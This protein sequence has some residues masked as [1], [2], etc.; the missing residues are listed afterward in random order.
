MPLR[1][2]WPPPMVSLPHWRLCQ[3]VLCS[4][5][6]LSLHAVRADLV[7]EANT[8]LN[9][10]ANLPTATGFETINALGS[11]TFSAPMCTAFP[12]GETNRL[13][14]LQR[15][16]TIRVV[17]NLGT[18]PASAV[19]MNLTTYLSN[20]GTPLNQG[21]ENGMLTMVFHPDYNQNGYFYVYYSIT[22][23]GQLYQRLAR[24]KATGTAGNYNAATSAD[25]ATQ[26]PLLTMLDQASNH[27][28]GDLAF[29]ADG[30]LYLSLGDEG[31]GGDQY[32]NARFINKDFW[33]QML[34]LDVDNDP[35]NFVPNAHSQASAAFPSAVHAGT[36][37]VPADNPF[38]GYTSWHGVTIS[39][40]TVRTEIFA[41]GLRNPFRFT[42]DPGTGRIFLGDV[43]QNIYEEVD[44]IVKGGDYGWS[45]REG[46]HA[47]GSPPSPTSPPA[48]YSTFRKD[49]IF[50][51]DHTDNGSGNDSIIHGATVCGGMIY[52]GN[53]F[54]ELYGKYLFADFGEGILA[55]LTETSAGTWTGQRLAINV[56]DVVDFGIDPRNGEPLL[57]T[58]SGGTIS[59]L[60]RT[61]T[62]PTQPPATLSATGAFSDLATLTPNTGIVP[63]E[64]NVD[65]WSDYA[66]KSRWFSI[67]NTSDTMTWSAS[68]NWTFPTGM[69]WIKHFDFETTRG[70]PATRRKLETRFLV[71]TATGVYGLS[72]KWRADQTD[73]DLVAEQGLSEVV[74]SSSPAQTWRY[75]SRG[76][77]IACHSGVAGHALSFNSPQINRAHDYG[78]ASQNQIEALSSAGYFSSPA[79]G[80]GSLPA[81][82]RADDG[83]QSLEW[84]VRSYLAVN[85]VQCHQ[86][87]GAAQGNWD[88]RYTTPI[89]SANLIYGL[90]LNDGGDSDN[91]FVTPEDP[92]HSMLLKRQQGLSA[93]RMPPLATNERDLVAEQLITDWINSLTPIASGVLA[94]DLPENSTITVQEDAG[95]VQIP[96]IRTDGSEGSVGFSI[97]TVNGTATTGTDFTAQAS[98]QTMGNGVE[99][100]DVPI[101]ILNPANTSEA[102]ETFTVMISAPTGGATLG[103]V[104]SVTVRIIDSS[105]TTAP[106]APSITTPAAAALVGANTGATINVTGTATDNKGVSSVKVKLNNGTFVDAALTAPE[107]ASTNWSLAVTPVTGA[108]T[109]TVQSF[110]THNNPS[111]LATRTFVVTRPLVVNASSTLGTVTAGFSPSSFR[112]VNKSLTITATPKPP[113]TTPAFAGAIFTGWN[114]GGQD[115][116]NGNVAFTPQRLNMATSALEKQSIIFL[117]REGLILTANFIANPFTSLAGTYNGLIRP[118]PTQPPPSGST[119]NNSTEG[120]FTA[121][122][123][124]TGAFSGKLTIDGLVLNVAGAFDNNGDA[125]FGTARTLT[126]T[127]ARPSKP[128]LIVALHLNSAENQVD[129]TVDDKISGTV[130]AREFKQSVTTSVSEVDSDRAF[131]NGTTLLVPAAYLGAANAN[132]VF[133]TVLPA[134]DVAD[135]PP[136]F[137]EKDYPRGSG[138]ATITITKGGVVTLTGTLAEGTT[139]TASSTLS[140]IGA[141]HANRF[142]LFSSL[143]TAKGFLSG[144]VQLDSTQAASDLAATNLQWLRPFINTSHYYPYGWP[145]VIKVDLMGAKYAALAGHS[146]LKAPNGTNLQPADADGNVTLTFSEGQLTEGL[147]KFANLSTADAVTK[148]PDNDPTFTLLINRT[149]GT[150][151]GTFVHTDDTM[152]SFSAIIY[153][154]GPSAAAH[155]FFL[156]KQPVPINY[157]GEG[158]KVILHGQP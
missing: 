31:G 127:V 5:A 47:Y 158:G 104:K 156:T 132:G 147:N 103:I 146:A 1:Y 151:S 43:G 108:N 153:Q 20:Q 118:S 81:F 85:C 89:D 137:T 13:Y 38:I 66:H 42:I 67:K 72:Y 154:K 27:N 61:G 134:K 100:L 99:S 21:G 150:A 88:A 15:G 129:P 14:V 33:G 157:T 39:A 57:C 56:G 126:L 54:A 91:R 98:P 82:A 74:P 124:N 115:V 97:A 35:A 37:R 152:P 128:S 48:G 16:G 34:R 50:E 90:L 55:V 144:F 149:T 130:T 84:R 86:P 73:A 96:I 145:E 51:Y 17:N 107:T 78:G 2:P 70:N 117:F 95:P 3:A 24:F 23:G 45:W 143:Y 58:L 30:Y 119:R 49:P 64:P 83:S 11:L 53:Q 76:E 111:P 28:G 109:I 114:L 120:F 138:M 4:L 94:I 44:I 9:L 12:A 122:V 136:G 25:P 116:A 148:I 155:G 79:S 87:G 26:A 93:P 139:F 133:T 101:T 131:Y 123:M 41:T 29:G 62:T 59:K 102:N 113:T 92:G 121:T 68:G 52:R 142:P 22:V 60:N 19:F 7:R 140:E 106:P 18:T 80:V 69:V 8:T 105:D 63:Y 40:N 110:D 71:K 10:P 36:Y 65:F 32:N 112:E 141:T 77:C 125:R 46:L 75:P 6:A 135:Q